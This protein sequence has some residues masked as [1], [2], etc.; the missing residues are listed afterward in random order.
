MVES[1]NRMNTLRR[2]DAKFSRKPRS[3]YTTDYSCSES[4]LMVQAVEWRGQVDQERAFSKGGGLFHQP[5]YFSACGNRSDF[6]VNPQT[7]G[8]DIDIWVIAGANEVSGA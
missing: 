3:P 1:G 4:F 8:S 2:R 5:I 6:W 7:F